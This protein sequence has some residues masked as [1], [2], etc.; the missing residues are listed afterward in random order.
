MPNPVDF[1]CYSCLMLDDD[2]LFQN[3]YKFAALPFGCNL[4][5]VNIYVTTIAEFDYDNVPVMFQ[6]MQSD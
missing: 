6:T 4:A 1:S 2:F 5:R 3:D